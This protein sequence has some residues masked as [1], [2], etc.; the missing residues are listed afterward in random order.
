MF[1][2]F[3]HNLTRQWVYFLRVWT[4]NAIYQKFSKIFLR[5]LWKMHCFSRFLTKFKKLCAEF[6]RVWT[7]KTIYWKF[8]ENF[9]KFLKFRN[10]ARIWDFGDNEGNYISLAA[11]K[12][13]TGIPIFIARK[14]HGNLQAF[15]IPN[16]IPLKRWI[17]TAV[18]FSES[19]LS[20][21][22][23]WKLVGTRTFTVSPSDFRKDTRNWIGRAQYWDDGGFF[24][25]IIDFQ[26][27]E[28]ALSIEQIVKVSRG[29]IENLT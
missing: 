18:T 6:L 7:K 15:E 2:Y 23:N 21:F 11:S 5:K 27:Y 3:S 25:K 9:R 10:W 22:L 17:H 28:R 13:I 16:A 8:W 12:D 26:V 20:I 1:G 19:S 29:N 14:N 4:K 24:G